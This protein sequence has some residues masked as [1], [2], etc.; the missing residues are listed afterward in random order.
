MPRDLHAL[1]GQTSL[2][3][4]PPAEIQELTALQSEREAALATITSLERQARVGLTDPNAAYLLSWLEPFVV[5][6]LDAADC[7]R[8]AAVLSRAAA[9]HMTLSM[10][11]LSWFESAL[12]RRVPVLYLAESA[13]NLS[14]AFAARRRY[15]E[16]QDILD[17][18]V[19]VTQGSRHATVLLCVGHSAWRR[20][21][22]SESIKNRRG[23]DGL[24]LRAISRT[25]IE[26][27]SNAIRLLELD[28][29]DYPIP[30][31]R[32]EIRLAEAIALTSALFERS[33]TRVRGPI[34]SLRS[35]ALRLQENANR[36]MEIRRTRSQV[37]AYDVARLQVIDEVAD[38]LDARE[39]IVDFGVLRRVREIQAREPDS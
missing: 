1:E 2:L 5:N 25:A 23:F 18:L 6:D 34:D 30:F 21:I 9:D 39:Q 13:L 17:R 14:V 16:A 15:R 19:P 3:I 8:G 28:Q 33:G 12:R 37:T 32:T 11:G 31:L 29:G 35:G 22:L 24:R 36:A 10:L 38:R 4:R 20:R 7:G 26:Q 27:A